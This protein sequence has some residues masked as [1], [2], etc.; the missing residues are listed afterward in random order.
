MRGR[1]PGRYLKL[2][3]RDFLSFVSSFRHP[4]KELTTVFDNNNRLISGFNLDL[5]SISGAEPEKMSKYLWRRSV[6][7]LFEK[8]FYPFVILFILI[9]FSSG[10]SV[11][12][13]SRLSL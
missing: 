5:S 9:L 6:F 11:A 13:K 8:I 12:V 4:G 2:D 10:S 7:F 1:S 3:R